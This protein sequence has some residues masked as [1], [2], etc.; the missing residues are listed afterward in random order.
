MCYSIKMTKPF[1]DFGARIGY[2]RDME[3]PVSGDTPIAMFRR[4]LASGIGS[5]TLEL[6]FNEGLR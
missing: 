4:S 6:P 3:M 5:A 1:H 2:Y